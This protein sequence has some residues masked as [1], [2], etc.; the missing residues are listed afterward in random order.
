MMSLK[1]KTGSS[2]NIYDLIIL[3]SIYKFSNFQTNVK[4]DQNKYVF[5]ILAKIG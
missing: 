1:K 3:S 2:K 5:L 4:N